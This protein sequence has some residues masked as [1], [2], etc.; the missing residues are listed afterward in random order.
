ML[1]YISSATNVNY[2]EI[3]NEKFK[4]EKDDIKR[5]VYLPSALKKLAGDMMNYDS[6]M[7]NINR[8]RYLSSYN[9]IDLRNNI[10]KYKDQDLYLEFYHESGL[11]DSIDGFIYTD[12]GGAFIASVAVKKYNDKIIAIDSIIIE[13]KSLYKGIFNQLVDVAIMD[14]KAN[15][16][17]ISESDNICRKI[18]E[19]CGFVENHTVDTKVTMYTLN[20]F[21]VNNT[22]E[23]YPVLI[24]TSYNPSAKVSKLIVTVTKSYFSHA[25]ISLDYKLNYL[26]SFGSDGLQKET[27]NGFKKTDSI[28]RV[29][30]V[31]VNRRD[32]KIIQKE[33]DSILRKDTSYN[34]RDLFDLYIEDE[35]DTTT[36][37]MICSQFTYYLLDKIGCKLFNKSINKIT[38]DDLAR[39]CDNEYDVYKLYEGKA[40]MYDSK[41]VKRRIDSIINRVNCIN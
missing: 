14:L 23:K 4:L 38:P 31:F 3:I 19:N 12:N 28:I 6:I 39:L 18:Y 22:K 7:D 36:D 5:I 2:D 26:Y 11:D 21:N 41:D 10:N 9:K 24:V 13:S 30:C 40:N 35:K 32:L 29:N 17:F 8:R 25:S 15:T 27:L 1:E 34:Y 20:R 37:S 33:I 16:V